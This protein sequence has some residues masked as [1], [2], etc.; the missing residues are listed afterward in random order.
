[1]PITIEDA[2]A[3]VIVLE[4]PQLGGFTPEHAYFVQH[5]AEH[6]AIAMNNAQLYERLRQSE[7]RY[8]AYVENVPDAIW[9]ADAEGRFTYWS[10]QAESL[11]GYAP[12]ELLGHTPADILIHPDETTEF[13]DGVGRMLR[14]AREGFALRHR[15]LRRDGSLLHLELSVKPVWDDA[16]RL[17]KYRGVA[18]DVSDQIRIQAQ[19]IQSAKL[20]GIGEM[21]SGVAHEL[22]NP[23]TTVIGYTELLQ[24]SEVDENTKADLHKIHDGATRAQRIVQSLLTFSRQT[25]PH[26]GPTDVNE[27][28]EHSITLRGYQLQVDGVEVVTELQ[29]NLPWTMD[30]SYQLEQVFLNI[31]NNAHQAMSQTKARRILTVRSTLADADTIRITFA[32]TGPGIPQEIL[33]R[34][35]DPFFTTKEV[36]LGTGL[37]LS[38]SHGIVQEHGGCIWAESAPGRGATFVIE[39]PIRSWAEGIDMPP[40]DDLASATRSEPQ[41]ILIIDDEQNVL[42]L[43][44]KALTD[45]GYALEGVMTADSALKRLRRSR[46]DLIIS[47]VTMPEWDGP[48]CHRKVRAVDPALAE[49]ILFV[50]EDVLS[51]DIQ[52]FLEKREGRWLR[53]PFAPEELRRAVR[54]VLEMEEIE[55]DSPSSSNQER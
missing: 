52:A 19:L 41:R 53:K 15:A 28:I 10:P 4:S 21:I 45:R 50:T 49:R 1:V 54:K 38:V 2:V 20:S 26:R 22:N 40:S 37:G 6:A 31:I 16:G 42:D 39:L 23:L 43:M 12:E 48:T 27:V 9:E 30:D 13:R 5:L 55:E 46:Y 32:D 47:D 33:N 51:S 36:G 25:K 34:V 7:E 3:G 44:V 11:T 24:T 8:R 29:E 18:R 17:V 35:F 14:E